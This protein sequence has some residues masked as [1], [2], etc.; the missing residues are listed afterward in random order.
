[1]VKG[2]V[3]DSVKILKSHGNKFTLPKLD[4]TTERSGRM[5]KPPYPEALDVVWSLGRTYLL[6]PDG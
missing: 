2:V 4:I 1:M 6:P 3:D 5:A